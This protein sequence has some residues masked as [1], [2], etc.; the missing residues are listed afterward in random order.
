VRLL[1]E[2]SHRETVGSP[3]R[4][5]GCVGTVFQVKSVIVALLPVLAGQGNALMLLEVGSL[6]VRLLVGESHRETV[7]WV[8]SP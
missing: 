5:R 3:G 6:T 4:P 7:G 1:D 8:V 2:G